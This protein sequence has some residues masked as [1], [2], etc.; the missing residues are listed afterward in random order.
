MTRLTRALSITAAASLALTLTACASPTPEKGAALT[1]AS[2]Y[3]ITA[4]SCGIDYTYNHAP[5][6]VLLGAPGI[7]YTL[8]ALGVAD[9]AIGYTLS[10]YPV[11]GIEDFPNLTVTSSDYTPSREFL[12]SAQ[13][14]LFLSN[15]EQQLLGDGAA[16][17]DD[18]DAIPSNLYVLG[19]YCDDAP[20]QASIDVVYNDIEQLGIIYNIPETAAE[21]V[22]DLKKRV[23]AAAALNSSDEELS[24]GAVTVFDGKVY[25]LGGSYYA[26]ILES[27]GFINGFAGLGA[28]WSEIT[29]EAVLASDLDVILV[30]FR[31]NSSKEAVEEAQALFANTPAAQNDRIIGVDAA[32]F[33]SA[34]VAIVDTIEDAA[35]QLAER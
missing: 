29:P 21:L 35:S 11:E 9:S 5:E 34:G 17:K 10:D 8:D 13:P 18:L 30:T 4:A 32:A 31:G 23:A 28:N 1:D 12:I 24:A 15:D 27:L 7:I 19:D 14:D 26:A 33:E 22:S 3:P 16:S 25:A 20:A 6:R 2:G